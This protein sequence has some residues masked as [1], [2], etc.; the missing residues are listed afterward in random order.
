MDVRLPKDSAGF[1]FPT[2]FSAQM[3]EFDVERL[4]PTLFYLAVTKGRQRGKR[5][6][7]P[8]ATQAYLDALCENEALVGFD[9]DGARELLDKWLRTSIVHMGTIGKARRGEQI[10]YLVPLTLMVYKSGLP[11]EIR[12]QRNVHTFLY[13]VLMTTLKAA[14][15]P[16]PE[17]L[18]YELFKDS[19]GAGVETLP[20]H[21]FDARYDEMTGVDL[22][23]LLSMR[24]LEG[25]APTP[26]APSS[27]KKAKR[28]QP[29][30]P[31]L[32]VTARHLGEDMLQYMSAYR[33]SSTEARVQGL[34]ALVN[35]ELLVYT[36]RLS[37]AT[38]ALVRDGTLPDA[39]GE[40]EDFAEPE[41]YVDF[42][43]ER[44]SASDALARAC[45][46]RHTEE[47]AALF[48]S[49]IFLR[50]L[51]AFTEFLP[52]L[53]NGARGRPDSTPAYLQLLVDC[54]RASEVEAQALQ[55]LRSIAKANADEGDE[56]PVDVSRFLEGAGVELTDSALDACVRVLANAQR[57]VGVTS[58]MKWFRA[59]GGIGMSFGLLS[60]NERGRR[61]WRYTMGDD[62]LACL[63][64]LAMSTDSAS[65][66]F[67]DA[68]PLRRLRLAEFLHWL[69]RRFGVLV[70]RPPQ[71][72]D[73][74]E[75]RAAAKANLET[76]KRRLRQMGFFE[77]LSDDFNAQYLT[78]RFMNGDA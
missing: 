51:H 74:T 8:T 44:G 52:A 41:I 24:Y 27:G 48:D 58:Y 20:S 1:Q 12:R 78:N 15:A 46:E 16:N 49:A 19:F 56:G 64:Q 67:T 73:D 75:S 4:L 26:P 66:T 76:F 59:V 63:V 47:I 34:M 45:V 14:K 42:T 35:F 13:E 36:L 57:S 3:D 40:G 28:S 68:R 31:A 77:A 10:Q 18:V 9:N 37:Y 5:V 7:E 72:L 38:N 22:Q 60:G 23:A 70:D 32:P 2:L 61:N 11:T 29:A 25:F 69:E 6:N 39:M 21:D 54:R 43:G 65:P 30:G 71:R 55:E 33:G 53:Q 62:L 50:T 17:Q